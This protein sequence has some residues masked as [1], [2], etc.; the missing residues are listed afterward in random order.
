MF[1]AYR[2]LQ[3]ADVVLLLGARLNWMM[4]FGAPPRFNPD[5]KTIPVSGGTSLFISASACMV[6]SHITFDIL[7]PVWFTIMIHL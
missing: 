7:I 5:V 1:H 4:H 6:I 2:A 3:E